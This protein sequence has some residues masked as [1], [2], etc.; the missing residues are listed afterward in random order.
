LTP[1]FLVTVQVEFDSGDPTCIPAVP[2]VDVS[3]GSQ[4]ASPGHTLDYAVVVT[5][6]DDA[7]CGASTLSLSA[8]LPEDWVGNVSPDTLTLSPG[9]SATANLSVISANEAAEASYGFMVNVSDAAESGHAAS[10]GASYVIEGIN[11]VDTEA[12]T[13]PGGLSAGLKGKNQKL[14]WNAAT[15]NVG[16]SAY[17]VWRDGARIGD[18][19]DTGYVDSAV[20]SG[21]TCTYTVSAYDAAGNMSASSSAVTIT[22]RGGSKSGGKGKPKK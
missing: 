9:Q 4:N 16:V 10:T 15:D 19:T 20:P 3:P 7:T 5:N 12:P 22:T 6:T 17:A 1:Q 11:E 18:T 2:T 13:V 21:K 14:T 8:S